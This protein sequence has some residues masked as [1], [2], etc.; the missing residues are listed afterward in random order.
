MIIIFVDF[1]EEVWGIGIYV[2]GE[3]LIGGGICL[4]FYFWDMLV[5][6]YMYVDINSVFVLYGVGFVWCVIIWDLYWNLVDEY[7]FDDD[8]YFGIGGNNMVI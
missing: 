7:G 2:S 8:I 6:F 3:V 1:V 4:F 5:D